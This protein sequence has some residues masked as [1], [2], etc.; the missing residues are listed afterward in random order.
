M[1]LKACKECGGQVSDLAK[2]CPQCGHPTPANLSIRRSVGIGCLGLMLTVFVTIPMLL[3]IW[4]LA[5]RP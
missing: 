4:Y 2:A 1:A 3:V 5:S